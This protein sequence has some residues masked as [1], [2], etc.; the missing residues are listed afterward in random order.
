LVL[1]SKPKNTQT[2]KQN[3]AKHTNKHNSVLCSN[4]YL[5]EKG[6]VSIPSCGQKYIFPDEP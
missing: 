6:D 4:D 1:I 5:N 2:N 3:K